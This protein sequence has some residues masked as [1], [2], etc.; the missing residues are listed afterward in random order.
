[1]FLTGLGLLF[2][3]ATVQAREPAATTADLLKLEAK[4][5]TVAEIA[6]PATVALVAETNGSSGSGVIVSRDGL[7]LTAAHVTQGLKEVDVYFSNGKKYLGKVLGSNFSK[8]VGMV[9]MVETRPWPL[10]RAG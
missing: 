6:L 4:V 2:F 10:C 5:A 1:M 3:S 8:D 7:I 9:K